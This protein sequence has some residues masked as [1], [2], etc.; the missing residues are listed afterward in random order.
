MMVHVLNLNNQE[1]EA[2]R[3]LWVKSQPVAQWDS[4]SKKKSAKQINF[5]IQYD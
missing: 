1:A 3:S 5:E 2:S 4:I